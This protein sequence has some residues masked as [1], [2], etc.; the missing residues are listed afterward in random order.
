MGIC[1]T[2]FKKEIITEFMPAK[3]RK[4][5]KVIIFC[6]GVPGVPHKDEVLE[7]WAEQGYWTFFPRYRGTWES[8]GEFLAE[9]PE[10]DLMDMIDGLKRPFK[11]YWSDKTFE[12]NPSSI[13]VVGSSFGGPAAILATRDPRV[14]KAIC[15]SPVVD[16]VAEDKNDPLEHLY[17]ILKEGYGAAYRIQKRNWNKLKKGNF[18]N[19]VAHLKEL[20]RKKILILHAQDDEVV[21][22]KSVA[23]FVK[24]L[25]CKS[26]FLKRGGHL[27]SSMLMTPKYSRVMDKFIRQ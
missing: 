13:T 4:S 12:V 20:D 19:P 8:H 18:Y 24:K 11:D 10:Q 15:I 25:K 14:D 26:I 6:A 21:H 7:Y 1:R 17:K 2:R 9:S 23:R 5:G 22:I 16:W 3:K 27:S